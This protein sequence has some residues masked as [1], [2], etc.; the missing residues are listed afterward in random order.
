MSETDYQELFRYLAVSAVV[1]P[2][3]LLIRYLIMNRML[4]GRYDGYGS[5][6]FVACVIIIT[7]ASTVISRHVA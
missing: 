3:V 2:L 4:K 6:V 1:A 7:L 5:L